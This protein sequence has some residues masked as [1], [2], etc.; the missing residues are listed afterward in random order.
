MEA[1]M[2]SQSTGTEE[3][4][5][6][7]VRSQNLQPHVVVDHNSIMAVNVPDPDHP[8]LPGLVYGL[9]RCLSPMFAPLERLATAAEQMLEIQTEQ[10]GFCGDMGV[11]ATTGGEE[12]RGEHQRQQ[13]QEERQLPG[14]GEAVSAPRES[15]VLPEP[16][17][18]QLAKLESQ[19]AEIR[20]LL[21]RQINTGVAR[22]VYSV[23]EVADR[24]GY[25]PWT[26]RQACNRK[27]LKATKGDDGR[28]RIPHEELIRLQE[29]GLPAEEARDS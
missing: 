16:R 23:N 5:I 29:Q 2:K 4:N 26:I 1:G 8:G 14:G 11:A 15:D 21:K 7:C 24:T 12:A 20:D 19:V 9:V 17:T 6:I 25:K 28:W 10:T 18:D 3:P 27:R 13:R 22:E